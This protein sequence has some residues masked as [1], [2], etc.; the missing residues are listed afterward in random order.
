VATLRFPA[1]AFDDL[2]SRLLDVAP[3]EYASRARAETGIT[4]IGVPFKA[5]YMRNKDVQGLQGA[6]PRLN[7]KCKNKE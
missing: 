2:A 4:G 5:G 6:T 7:S 3:T 1:S